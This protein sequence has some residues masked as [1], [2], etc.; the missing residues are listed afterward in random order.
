MSSII[1]MSVC[2]SSDESGWTDVSFISKKT[3]LPPSARPEPSGRARARRHER[4][5]CAR[6]DLICIYVDLHRSYARNNIIVHEAA[7]RLDVELFPPLVRVA[8]A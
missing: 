4:H 6:L 5:G 3:C 2:L 7:M 8:P 1:V